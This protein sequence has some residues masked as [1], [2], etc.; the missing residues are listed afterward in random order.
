[1]APLSLRHQA[2]AAADVP[3]GGVLWR[4]CL[5]D[6]VFLGEDAGRAPDALTGGAAYALLVEIVCG[7]RSPLIGETEVQAQFKAFLTSLDAREHGA[8]R[9]LGQRVLTDAK[10][11]R[12]RHLQ[13][14]GVR[15]YSGLVRSHVPDGT[16]VVLVGTGTLATEIAAA[17]APAHQIDQW[18][19]RH[20]AMPSRAAVT[21]F[22]L[23]SAA[24]GSSVQSTEPAVLIIAA[25]AGSVA[26]DAVA[27]GYP[28]LM[29]VIDLRPVDER[30][31]LATAA[32]AVTL[33]DLFAEAG[34]HARS[35]A[36]RVAAARADIAALGRAY[37]NRD[38]L[39]PFGWDDL[40]A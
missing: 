17:L 4:T 35:A 33:D 40:C 1:M 16:R 30:T 8:L 19:R 26:L 39:R 14:F 21:R 37:V 3:S 27:A 15:S 18:G 28:G 9:R 11:I 7:L 12:S 5:R 29:R 25:P 31:P 38:E 2:P 36:G 10:R 13:G 34:A 32:P 6:V 22:E 24:D 20:P 23:F